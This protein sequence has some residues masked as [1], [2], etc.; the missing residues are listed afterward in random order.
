MDSET[1]DKILDLNRTLAFVYAAKERVPYRSD[2][3]NLLEEVIQ[4]LE[5]QIDDL[6]ED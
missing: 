1:L 5:S 6:R 3:E 2:N 4:D